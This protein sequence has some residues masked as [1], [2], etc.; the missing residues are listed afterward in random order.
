MVVHYVGGE[1]DSYLPS[2]SMFLCPVHVILFVLLKYSIA[3]AQGISWT[4][5]RKLEYRLVFCLQ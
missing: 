4:T 2:T 3:L 5:E 1:E